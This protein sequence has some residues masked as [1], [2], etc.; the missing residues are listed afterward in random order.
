[1]LHGQ[2]RTLWILALA[3][4]IGAAGYGMNRMHNKR[5]DGF[6]IEAITAPLDHNPAYAIPPMEPPQRQEIEQILSQTFTYLAKGTQSFVFLSSDKNYVIKFFKQQHL[7]IPWY[8]LTFANTPL[9]NHYMSRKVARRTLKRSKIYGGCKLAY[10]E[11]QADTGVVYLHL[12]PSTDLP[13]PLTLID[14]MGVKHEID[15]NTVAFFLQ[16]RGVPLYT[17]FMDY[18]ERNDLAGANKALQQLFDYLVDRSRRGI[19]DRDPAYQQNLGFIGGRAANLDVG[20]LTKDP[21]IKNRIEYK[22]RIQEHLVDLRSWMLIH[23]PE[24]VPSYDASLGEL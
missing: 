22:R 9:V 7:R 13:S 3:F 17:A 6:T 12:T 14:K 19:L 11:L 20:N 2:L 21:L 8:C 1:M 23:F 16:R 24:L 15:P 4:L 5:T 18:R 10:D